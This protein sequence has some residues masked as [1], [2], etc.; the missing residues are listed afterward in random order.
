MDCSPKLRSTSAMPLILQPTSSCDICM[1][2]YNCDE[3][4]RSPHSIDCGHIFCKTCVQ[5]M[6]RLFVYSSDER[7][8]CVRGF[9][10]KVC[11]LCRTPFVVG[12]RLH[13]DAVEGANSVRNM[14]AHSSALLERI[15]LVS[16]ESSTTE[17]VLIVVAEVSD[18]LSAHSNWGDSNMASAYFVFRPTSLV[19]V[20]GLGCMPTCHSSF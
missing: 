2:D 10:P 14:G 20:S 13:V 19:A 5:T 6:G 9:M 16:N 3:L 11:P 8:S 1:E 12:L 4:A 15:A 18:W 7:L 17:D